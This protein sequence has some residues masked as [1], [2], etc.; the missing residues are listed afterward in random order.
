MIFNM[1]LAQSVIAMCFKKSAIIPVPKKT[2]PVC[3]NNYHPPSLT[4]VVMKC[5]EQLVKDYI[6]SSLP[7]TLDPPQFAYHPS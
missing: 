2:R 5:F 4:S 3:L 1:S 7:S 6:C